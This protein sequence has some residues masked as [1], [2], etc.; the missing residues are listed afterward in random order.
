MR[1]LAI[2]TLCAAAAAP[3]TPP[4]APPAPAQSETPTP[5]A[6]GLYATFQTSMGNIVCKLY[7]KEAPIAVRNFVGLAR[8]TKTWTDPKTHRPVRRP[9]YN[10]TVFHRVIPDFMIQG[11][12]PK[13]DGTGSPGYTFKNED[14]QFKFDIKGVLAMANAGRDTNGSQFFITVAP[15]PSLNGDYTV[16]G[17]VIQGQEVA[18]AISK[19]PRD[20][21]DRPLTPVKLVRVTIQHIYAPGEKPPLRRRPAAQP[22]KKS[23]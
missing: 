21:N 22:A 16:F 13:G 7:D 3:Q 20:S 12:D 15:Y 1:I 2:L 4:A 6:P 10:G 5:L 14:N 23:T 9:L 19:V 17:Q 11:G 18:D 8:G